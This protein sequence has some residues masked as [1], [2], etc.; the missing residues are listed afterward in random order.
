[1]QITQDHVAPSRR[2]DWSGVSAE[3]LTTTDQRPYDFIFEGP[4]LY[5]CFGL[6]G[7]RKDSIVRVD[8]ERAT[9]FTEITNRFHI[10]PAGARFEGFAVPAGPQRFVQ[11]YID[12]RAGI[13][14]PEIDLGEIAPRLGTSGAALSATARKLESAL[15]TPGP[16][17]RL[18]G[19]T[20]GCALAI[21]LLRW[22]RGNA[23]FLK[24]V[25][26]GLSPHHLRLITRFID[27]HLSE[28]IGL[29]QLA[30]L[31]GLTPSHF[32]RAFRR[33]T[34]LPPHRYLVQSRVE[35][36]KLL[37]TSNRGMSVTEVALEAG[38]GG[39]TQLA[40]VFKAA[41]GVS[42]SEYRASFI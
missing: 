19:E 12:A 7:R 23:D 8:G 40:R 11:V 32:C 36:A 9:S 26:G 18:Y 15:S 4:A 13:L 1:L 28:D 39:S 16:L 33:S 41:L 14:H 10:V 42:P 34:G 20:L 37:L 38:F 35:R 27:D 31:V 21:E 17:N 6:S 5:L 2:S 30:T 29:V 3:L 24:P 22:Q 25:S